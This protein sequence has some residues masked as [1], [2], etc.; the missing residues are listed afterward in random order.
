MVEI[1][2]LVPCLMPGVGKRGIKATSM[3]LWSSGTMFSA[4]NTHSKTSKSSRKPIVDS[5]Q[6]VEIVTPKTE[7]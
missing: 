6:K 2:L 1:N 7:V 4:S 5:P 3:E